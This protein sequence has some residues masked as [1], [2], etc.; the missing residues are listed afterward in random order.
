MS[1][2]F[3]GVGFLSTPG[4]QPLH[5]VLSPHLAF[6]F[7]PFHIVVSSWPMPAMNE[8]HKLELH[9]MTDPTDDSVGACP[10]DVCMCVSNTRVS[11]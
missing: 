7:F 5:T 6:R 8:L 9:Q 1:L 2:F 4:I 11:L 3:S 10:V